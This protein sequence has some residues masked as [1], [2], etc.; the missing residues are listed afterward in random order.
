VVLR[1]DVGGQLELLF[2]LLVGYSLTSG[3]Y[4]ESPI[5][6]GYMFDRSSILSF[7]RASEMCSH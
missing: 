6:H 2:E 4:I 7:C 3:R 5:I 1:F